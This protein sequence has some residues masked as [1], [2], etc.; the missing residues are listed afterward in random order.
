MYI[1]ETGGQKIESE[2]FP[3]GTYALIG[4]Q[5]PDDKGLLT[6]RVQEG[7][8]PLMNEHGK[9]CRYTEMAGKTYDGTKWIHE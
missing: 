2:D 3:A 5:Y 7:L 9:Q 1:Y 4:S 6:V 8:T